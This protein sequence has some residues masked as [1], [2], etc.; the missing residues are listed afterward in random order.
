MTS[1]PQ[2]SGVPLETKNPSGKNKK[3]KGSTLTLKEQWDE[4]LS[5][6]FDSL[7][8]LGFDASSA[9]N[10]VRGLDARLRVSLAIIG[11]FI[12]RITQKKVDVRPAFGALK[13]GQPVTVLQYIKD[14][15]QDGKTVTARSDSGKEFK[16]NF[17]HVTSAAIIQESKD[18]FAD[19][20]FM[21]KVDSGYCNSS[22]LFLNEGK[23][24]R[25]TYESLA[26]TSCSDEEFAMCIAHMY[27]RMATTAG[28]LAPQINTSLKIRDFVSKQLAFNSRV[29]IA[30]IHAAY[31]KICEMGK[32]DPVVPISVLIAILSNSEAR[33][34]DDLMV[35][36]AKNA[37][38][39]ELASVARKT[40]KEVSKKSKSKKPA[41]E[42]G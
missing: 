23:G 6:T 11:F 42:E 31:K 8:V 2:P 3:T 29:T 25:W 24:N 32:M 21:G 4:Q 37:G 14:N 36:S 34:N 17:S 40:I 20:D 35:T 26:Y 18:L 28:Y 27:Y 19:N 9:F 15:F 30:D 5:D 13:F 39:R 12:G 41:D 22:L 10:F 38:L 1:T 16:V 33:R 7:E